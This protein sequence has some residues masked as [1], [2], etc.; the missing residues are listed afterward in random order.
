[1]LLTAYRVGQRAL[2]TYAHPCSPK[3]FT[4]P[5]LFACLVLKEF[6]QLDYR[7]LS[8]FLQ[9][10]P[11]LT[12]AI[13]LEPVPHFS[14]FHKAARRM[15]RSHRAQGLLTETV[16]GAIRTG[17]IKKRVELA[18]I[19]GTGFETR[20]ISSYYVKRRERACKTGY[21]TTTYTRYPYANL[22]CE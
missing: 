15:L 11:D 14:T 9:D 21:Q 19:D 17:R 4:Q 16:D 10:T 8:A 18:A 1:M 13:D 22:V 12:R 20:H 7:K 3:K 6:L 2:P 5:Q